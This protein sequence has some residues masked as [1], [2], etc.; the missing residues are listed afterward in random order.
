MITCSIGVASGYVSADLIWTGLPDPDAVTYYIAEAGLGLQKLVENHPQYKD[1]DIRTGDDARSIVMAVLL[2]NEEDS[3]TKAGIYLNQAKLEEALD[4]GV[5]E[6]LKD[7]TDEYRRVLRPI[8]QSVE[9]RKGKK[10]WL[11][12]KSYIQALKGK[13]I[14]PT[15]PGW[16][17]AVIAVV[18]GIGG[19]VAGLVEGFVTSIADVF[20]GIYEMIKSI[21]S[22][23]I[24]LISGEAIKAAEEFYDIVKEM[25]AGELFKMLKEALVQMI[26]SSVEEFS[27]KWNSNNTYNQWN[28][29]GYVIGYILAELLMII[30]TAGTATTAKW[31]GKLGKIGEKLAKILSKVLGKVDDLLDKVPGR[32]RRKNRRGRRQHG[33]REGERQGAR[34]ACGL[35][36][37]QRDCRDSRCPRQ[38]RVGGGALPGAAQAEVQMD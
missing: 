6:G 24:D 31:L 1:Y 37:G 22:F 33:W 14:I 9:L 27:N 30:F 38:P 2:A 32:K 15:R 29:R 35:D 21:I 36:V 10:I 7:A 11:P 34:A 16:K 5:W 18:K 4:P 25:S 8:L 28:F 20:I 13:G 19:F 26:S 3:R 23:V 17:N 12:G